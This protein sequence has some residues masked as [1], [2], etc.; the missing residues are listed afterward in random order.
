MARARQRRRLAWLTLLAVPAIGLVGFGASAY[1]TN[2][3]S[4]AVTGTVGTMSSA[5]VAV[6]AEATALYPG[7]AA[8]LTLSVT[9]PNAYSV[10]LSAVA[11]NP[12]P[13]LSSSDNGCDASTYL[14]IVPGTLPS[15]AIAAG[16]TRTYTL[17]DAA[18]LSV[19]AVQACQGATF[20]IPLL[21]TVKR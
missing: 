6:T 20:T 5:T 9:N 15:T 2:S 10:V 11:V 3:G 18:Q 13:G 7:G 1:W 19:N 8:D 17:T 14:S 16:A 21:V 12:S 4:A